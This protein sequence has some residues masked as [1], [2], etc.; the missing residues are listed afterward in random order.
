MKAVLNCVQLLETPW[1]AAHKA[2]PPV[3]YSRQEYWSGLPF[4][5]S[6]HLPKLGI[7]PASLMLAGGFLYHCDTWEAQGESRAGLF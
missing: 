5:S 4:S 7:K 1:T 2:P 3:E 6:G